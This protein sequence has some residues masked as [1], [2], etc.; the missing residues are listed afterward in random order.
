VW[1]IIVNGPGR[2]DVPFVVGSGGAGVGREKSN[3][4]VLTGEPVSRRHARF[5]LRGENLCFEDLGS[6]NGSKLNGHRVKGKIPLKPGDALDIGAFA[7]QVRRLARLENLELTL[8]QLDAGGVRRFRSGDPKGRVLLSRARRDRD[9]VREIE[10]LTVGG[11]EDELFRPAFGTLILHLDQV[12][13]VASA[14]QAQRLLEEALDWML[15]K[16]DGDDG[17]LFLRHRDGLMV[18]VV[19]RARAEAQRPVPVSTD[20]LT[21]TLKA[22]KALAFSS[23]RED[24]RTGEAGSPQQQVLCATI[25]NGE[26]PLGALYVN[27]PDREEEI[28]PFLDL[29]NAVAVLAERAIT[30][31]GVHRKSE[32]RDRTAG[33]L[34]RHH[35]PEIVR[36]ELQEAARLGI[37]FT[38]RLESKELGVLVAELHGLDHKV[39]RL[40]PERL[41]PLLTELY[42]C[43]LGVLLSFE[44]TVERIVEGRVTA[45]FG[46]PA[47]HP[48]DADRM[49]QAALALREEWSRLVRRRPPAERFELRVGLSFGTALVGIVGAPARYDYVALGEVVQTARAICNAAEPGQILLTHKAKRAVTSGIS[50]A[51][52]DAPVLLPNGKTQPILLVAEEE[53]SV[54]GVTRRAPSLL[55]AD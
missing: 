36:A 21:A 18:P 1:Q 4:I 31:Y 34:K 44:A 26:E 14:E 50:V 10:E 37:D 32:R 24:T 6:R 33:L 5:E 8:P 54:T 46:A 30:R 39:D 22:G 29:A 42:Q 19:V 51:P 2:I 27:R 17:V 48:D 40:A 49:V 43:A 3:Q 45:L 23:I 16:V 7:L 20:V 13:Q 28:A 15:K 47:S 41:G 25:G 38:P 55:D 52:L 12:G 9:L 11:L 35:G 53:S